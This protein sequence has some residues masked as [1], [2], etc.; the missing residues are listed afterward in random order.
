MALLTVLAML[1]VAAAVSLGSMA[2]AGAADANTGLRLDW[3][4]N[5]APNL[6]VNGLLPGEQ[7]SLDLDVCNTGTEAGSL[8]ATAT[9]DQQG[10]VGD[11]ARISFLDGSHVLWSGTPNQI[12]GVVLGTNLLDAG[13]SRHLSIV[14][15]LPASAGNEIAGAHFALQL[16]LQLTETSPDVTTPVVP[17]SPGVTVTVGG[18]TVTATTSATAVGAA[19]TRVAPGSSL[20]FTGA[21]LAD[22]ALVALA[23]IAVGATL[24]T[25]RRRRHGHLHD[26]EV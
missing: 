23:T 24:T 19:R 2:P 7:R 21:D 5:T 16:L 12:D 10:P 13:S 14:L 11:V 6:E 25:V 20:P 22:T 18:E 15:A 8:V 9:E 26:H 3:C 17:T 4:N 1:A